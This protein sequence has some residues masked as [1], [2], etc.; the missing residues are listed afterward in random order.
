MA[1]FT[2]TGAAGDG[3]FQNPANWNPQ[4][5]PG[6]AATVLIDPAAPVTINVADAIANLT[7]AADV[8]L[9]VADYRTLQLGNGGTLASFSNSGTLVLDNAYGAGLLLDARTTSLT[10]TGTI[11]L[12]GSVLEAKSA[13]QGLVNQNTIAGYGYLGNGTLALT[14]AAAGVI[15]A[16]VAGAML[17][18][19]T[20]TATL[21]NAGLLEATGGGVLQI[22]SSVTNTGTGS[23][24]ANGGTVTFTNG[25]ISGG[26]LSASGGGFLADDGTLTLNGRGA[27]LYLNANLAIA[28]YAKLGLSG[29]IANSGTLSETYIHG[30]GIVI[31]PATG[32]GSATLAGGGTV[33]LQSALQASVSGDV[34]SNIDNMIA[35]SGALGAGTNLAIVNGAAG[36][37][38]ATGSLVLDT[39]TATLTNHGLVEATA[40]GTLAIG[41]AISNGVTGQVTASGGTI[42]LGD[43]SALLGGTLSAS[44]GGV[45]TVSSA[46]TYSL[47]SNL[48]NDGTIG[49]ADGA[50]SVLTGAIINAGAIDEAGVDGIG[51]L[52][53]AQSGSLGTVTLAGGGL[54]T[55]ASGLQAGQSGEALD[56]VGNTITGAGLLGGGTN[57]A[58][59]NGAAGVIDATG[60]MTLDTGTAT[61][62][63]AGLI[64]ASGTG[65]LTI[66]NTVI[67]GAAGQV[68]AA[69]GTVILGNGADI[70]GGTLTGNAGGTILAAT[71]GGTLAVL[72]GTAHPLT[73]DATLGVPDGGGLMLEG[74]IVN[75]GAII[76]AYVSGP[77]IVVAGGTVFTNN[78]T[79]AAGVGGL[80]F[81]TGTVLTN[82]HGTS[83]GTLTGG[84]YEALGNTLSFT[85]AALGTLSGGTVLDE[86]NGGIAFGGTDALASLTSIQGGG[87]VS[88]ANQS[89]ISAHT[90]TNA[91]TLT[92]DAATYGL[93]GLVNTAA[94]T[95]GGNGDFAAT[96]R[97]TGTIDAAGGELDLTG[98]TSAIGGTITGGA[99]DFVGFGGVTTLAASALVTASDLAVLNAA[100]LQLGAK[101][102]FAGTFDIRGNATLSGQAL[103]VSGL[104]EQVGTGTGTI[105][106]PVTST[107]TIAID[108][109]G[110][111]AFANLF[112]SGAIVDEGGFTD[113]SALKGGTLTV[114]ASASASVATKAGAANSLLSTLTVQGGTL[115][116]NG[117]TLTVTGD[118][119]NTAAGSGNSYTPFAGVTGSIVGSGTR[120]AVVGVDG[121]KIT[122]VNGTDTITVAAG[123]TAHFEIKNTGVA[124]AALLRG[125]IETS[126]NGGSITGTA[127]TGSGV[128]AADFGP[129]AGGAASGVYAIAYDGSAPLSGEAIHIASDFANVAGIT[130]DIVS[131]S[132]SATAAP[133]W[134][135][136]AAPDVR[137][138]LQ[139]LA[140][141]HG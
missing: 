1:T 82:D 81:G 109:G 93:A 40:N 58:I 56:N 135:R 12:A 74:T 6:S 3:N 4:Q 7:D 80:T 90:L 5:V 140:L 22:D 133:A 18:V 121:T 72:D 55:L 108:Q 21:A 85:G 127:L 30:S 14:D 97:S 141:H 34:L 105:S 27:E 126:E 16:N 77:G 45:V 76:P 65:A 139:V 103:T 36:L 112:S 129:L 23:I 53:G 54:I 43:G 117:T 13:G 15:D 46:L 89:D 130:I 110:T 60:A 123:G 84:T 99:G 106:A 101:L 26:T 17:G 118:Y 64:E 51:L 114:G 125:A 41:S 70:E 100:S 92:L 73:V 137:D 79:L 24:E 59:V 42:T 95:L 131:A 19:N 38:D 136:S 78:G 9:E 57:L 111:L 10:G 75:N 104:F 115:N 132:G 94:G 33:L 116:T 107:G 96:L 35:G 52:A 113:A 63:N 49:I 134:F 62:T 67:D 119:D 29:T 91:G 31:G 61:V 68:A 120:L 11:E 128:T 8:T 83:I 39:G 28:D 32:T 122:S 69:G 124:T 37:I 87:A 71:S 48:T 102:S 25:T 138:D 20:G 47:L 98:N 50:A 44:G 86:S 2:W 66:G 88:L